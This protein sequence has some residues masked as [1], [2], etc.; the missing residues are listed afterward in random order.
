MNHI[1]ACIV[2]K[3][4]IYAVFSFLAVFTAGFLPAQSLSSSA[5]ISIIFTHDIHSHFDVERCVING[6]ASERGGFARM[7]TVINRIKIDYPETFLLDAGDFAMGTP[8]QTIFSSEASELRMMG[9]LGFDAATLGNHEFDYRTRGLTDML[10]TAVASGERLPFIVTANIDWEKTLADRNRAARAADRQKALNRYGGAEYTIIEKGGI[11]AAVFGIMGR[12]ADS[13]APLSGLYFKDQIEVSK[14]ITAKIKTETSADII[15]CLSHSGTDANSQKSEDELLAKAVPEI[16]VIISGH[17]HTTLNK[18]IIIGNTIIVSCG[19]HAYNIGRLILARNGNRYAV[20]EYKLMPISGDLPKDSA[21]E[22]AIEKFRFL[23]DKNYLSRF[24]YSYNQVLSYTD[25]DFTPVEHFA[26][27]QGEDT[28]GNLISDSYI[29]AIKKAEGSNYRK[30]DMAVVPSGVVRSSFTKGPITAADAFNGS[31]LG[32]GPDMVPGYPLVNIYLTGKELKTVAEIDASVSTLMREARLYMSGL[33]YAYNPRRLLLNRVTKVQL[34]NPDGS[35]SELDNNKFYRVIGGLYSCQM[36]GAVE[37]QSFGLLKVVPK[38]ENGNPITDFEEHIIYN[39]NTELK[40]WAALANYL[41][42]FGEQGGISKIPEYYSRL[43]GRKIE[44]TGRSL[45]ALLKNP[46]K[47]FFIL[48]G[49]ILLV[50]A[51][52][53]V[54]ICLIIRAVRRR[55]AKS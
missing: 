55:R 37:A 10:N 9:L 1:P 35:L 15:I 48:L 7:K 32:I 28:L 6:K 53:I 21:V 44:E 42:S 41:E 43:Q 26:E 46:N 22:S 3:L 31:S 12:Q 49:V 30:I 50:L 18:P 54:P 24:G 11:K 20:S 13:Y 25:F 39:G 45:W 29:A 16:D 2:K 14:E 4:K 38:D 52:I 34:M 19:E 23:V 5:E 8:Y 17:T 40:E 27:V 47:I 36:L 33:S 51:I